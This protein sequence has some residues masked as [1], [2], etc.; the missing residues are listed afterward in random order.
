M[1]LRCYCA[2]TI[3]AAQNYFKKQILAFLSVCVNR[4]LLVWR[5]YNELACVL[6]CFS[7]IA[8][9]FSRRLS[10]NSWNC[11]AARCYRLQTP[12]NWHYAVT[13][14]VCDEYCTSDPTFRTQVRGIRPPTDL[15]VLLWLIRVSNTEIKTAVGKEKQGACELFSSCKRLDML[16]TTCNAS[17]LSCVNSFCAR[18][19]ITLDAFLSPCR[20]DVTSHRGKAKQSVLELDYPAAIH[21]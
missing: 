1:W 11:T 18:V 3:T 2:L 16:V 5:N 13:V 12:S 17:A 4:R 6:V 10:C 9:V 20:A 19:V 8:L 7:C 14:A 15:S 21:P